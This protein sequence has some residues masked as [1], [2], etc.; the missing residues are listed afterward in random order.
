MSQPL[1]KYTLT[2][3]GRQPEWLSSDSRA[4]T[5]Q[6]SAPANKPGKLPR[7]GSPQ[8][9]IYLGIASGDPDSDG[10][11]DGYVGTI[12]SKADLQTYITEVG[13]AAD[14]KVVTSTLTGIQTATTT[15]LSTAWAAVNTEEGYQ[16]GLSTS[17]TTKRTASGVGTVATFTGS[18][19]VKIVTASVTGSGSTSTTVDTP[20][21]VDPASTLTITGVSTSVG[22]TTTG[23]AEV[24]FTTTTTTT[25]TNT[26]SHTDVTTN[27]L[28]SKSETTTDGVT[29]RTDTVTTS[30]YTNYE[31]SYDYAAEA[32][33][34]W[35]IHEAINS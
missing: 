33:R 25:T 11:P 30:E 34:L 12:G 22:V 13:V 14:Y 5:G 21:T 15:G 10:T 27:T 7:F 18:D 20:I 23:G 1:I 19:V 16:G 35:D 24:G 3:Q 31:T 26:Y 2:K 6:H 28:T 4:F 9:N 17:T 8:D 32:T 29:T